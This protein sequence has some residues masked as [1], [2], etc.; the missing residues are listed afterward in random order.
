MWDQGEKAANVHMDE[1]QK[2]R[3]ADRNAA[4]V[5]L[6]LCKY[7]CGKNLNLS[8]TGTVVL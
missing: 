8:H 7:K 1:I 4:S 5:L 3:D 6:I 2:T